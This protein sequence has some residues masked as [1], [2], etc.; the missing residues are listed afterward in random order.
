MQQDRRAESDQRR[1]RSSELRYVD[2]SGES[3]AAVQNPAGKCP[4]I[5]MQAARWPLPPSHPSS[6]VGDCSCEMSSATISYPSPPPFYFSPPGAEER[7]LL[8]SG[9]EKPAL[10]C[11]GRVFNAERSDLSRDDEKT[12]KTRETTTAI[13]E[14]DRNPCRRVMIYL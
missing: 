14:I 11:N 8:L 3:P 9:T 13:L 7:R 1:R 5:S 2:P 10:P 6:R 12:Q 4:R